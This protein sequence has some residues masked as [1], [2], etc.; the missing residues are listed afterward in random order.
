M[1]FI[2]TTSEYPTPA[3]RPAYSV[4]NKSSAE[5]VSSL[6]AI[7]WRKQLSSMMVDLV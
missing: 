2:V 3:R 4:I 7:H 1:I 6:R 5:E